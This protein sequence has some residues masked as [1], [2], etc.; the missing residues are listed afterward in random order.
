VAKRRRR[1]NWDDEEKQM[2][3]A[4]TRDMTVWSDRAEPGALEI[5]L[6]GGHRLRI[7]GPY[8]ADALA[9]VIWGLSS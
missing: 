7:K 4:Q 1:R 3:C 5:D 6:T 9:W 8:A 2:I